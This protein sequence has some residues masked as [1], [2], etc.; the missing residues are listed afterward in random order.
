MNRKWLLTMAAVVTTAITVVIGAR[1]HAPDCDFTV[2]DEEGVLVPLD[3]K[4]KE[5]LGLF[6]RTGKSVSLNTADGG[7]RDVTECLKDMG[8]GPWLTEVMPYVD[9]TVTI[10]SPGSKDVIDPPTDIDQ[11]RI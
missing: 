1:S 7:F 3:T 8:Y 4:T 2:K 11:T 6:E 9:Q 10:L 5:P